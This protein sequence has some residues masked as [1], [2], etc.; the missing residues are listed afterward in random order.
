[1]LEKVLSWDFIMTWSEELFQRQFRISKEDFL[2][3]CNKMKDIYPGQNG[4]FGI[5]CYKKALKMGSSLSILL[6][7][8]QLI[9]KSS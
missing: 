7:V 2:I 3:N 4:E 6:K 8:A 1:V 9:L 5:K